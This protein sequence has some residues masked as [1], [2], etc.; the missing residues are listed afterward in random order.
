MNLKFI[1]D[2]LCIF[3]VVLFIIA[4]KL[5]ATP[6]Q[7]G[8]FCNDDSIRYPY[9][10]SSISTN[11]L[12]FYS[13]IIPASIIVAFV[14]GALICKLITDIVKYNVGR[15]RPHFWAICVPQINC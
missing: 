7:Q 13:I 12:Y 9:K 11:L 14:F 1:A 8:I 3:F 10:N 2:I 5:F 15:L 6:F 4:I